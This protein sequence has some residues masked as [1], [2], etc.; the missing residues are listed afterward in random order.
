[1]F[2]P[3][4]TGPR[5]PV[6]GC[7]HTPYPLGGIVRH[8][9]TRTLAVSAAAL[10]L[11]AV[12]GIAG[13]SIPGTGNAINGCY[14]TANGAL[15]VIDTTAGPCKK[16]ETALNWNQSGQPGAPGTDGAD[17]VSGYERKTGGTQTFTFQQETPDF[18]DLV[19]CGSG[20]KAIGGGG[21]AVINRNFV[22]T[23]VVIEDTFPTD[24]GSTWITDFTPRDGNFLPGDIVTWDVF[25]I[26]AT[27]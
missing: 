6:L 8:I 18:G 16:G 26:C 14:T 24:D 17:G 20:R 23:L 2:D 12:G 27:A 9:P 7:V 11:I 1:M 4:N 15:R 3:A 13:A 25:A 5:P 10:G 19:N 22:R 21:D